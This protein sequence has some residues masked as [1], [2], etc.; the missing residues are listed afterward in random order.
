MK[1]LMETLQELD[2][3]QHTTKMLIKISLD[4]QETQEQDILVFKIKIMNFLKN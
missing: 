4:L 3:D 2:K 1:F